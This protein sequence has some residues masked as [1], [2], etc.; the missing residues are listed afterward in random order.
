MRFF[1]D[2]VNNTTFNG[3]LIIGVTPVMWFLGK[4]EHS[5]PLPH[6]GTLPE[7]LATQILANS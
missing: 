4:G 2:I 1:E 6:E 7:R 5:R 3:T